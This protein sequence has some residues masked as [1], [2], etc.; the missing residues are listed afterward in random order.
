[1]KAR[2]TART[3]KGSRS[4]RR[5]SAVRLDLAAHD[6]LGETFGRLWVHSRSYAKTCDRCGRTERFDLPELRK[7]IIYLDQ[8]ALIGMLRALHPD[9]QE[10]SEAEAERWR[11]LSRNLT[12]SRGSSSSSARNS[13]PVASLA[14]ATNSP[15]G[16]A[17]SG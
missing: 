9:A 2:V 15:S 1:M 7:K 14:Q 12:G 16:T 11:A 5:L 3:A 17:L 6:R 10:V 8:F 4:W 13:S